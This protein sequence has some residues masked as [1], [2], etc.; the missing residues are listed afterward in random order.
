M[1]LHQDKTTPIIIIS[2]KSFSNS[3]VLLL[4]RA[5][6]N[7]TK[8]WKII[9]TYKLGPIT[10]CRLQAAIRRKR[11]C[12]NKQHFSAKL[13]TTLTNFRGGKLEHSTKV[14]DTNIRAKFQFFSNFLHFFNLEVLK[15]ESSKFANIL[16]SELSTSI[17]SL[18][19]VGIGFQ[20]N[21]QKIISPRNF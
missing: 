8:F 12:I 11:L 7:K 2:N 10:T 6:Q 16:V 3:F 1:D 15:L 13:V 18:V 9:E 17:C 19:I 20:T 5:E 14:I 21:R 4:L